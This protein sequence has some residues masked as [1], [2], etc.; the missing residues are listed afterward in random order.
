MLREF[1][2]VQGRSYGRPE[3]AREVLLAMKEA[4]LLRESADVLEPDVFPEV[5]PR[6]TEH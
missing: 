1:L 6:R 3:A 4:E 5:P 2:V